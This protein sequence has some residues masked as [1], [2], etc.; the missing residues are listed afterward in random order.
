MAD[1]KTKKIELTDELLSDEA[2]DDVV[3]GRASE[4]FQAIRAN[5]MAGIKYGVA[6]GDERSDVNPA[7]MSAAFINGD[8][9]GGEDF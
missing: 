9:T 4:N 6:H 7:C 3:G 2:L 5:F 1:D 8:I